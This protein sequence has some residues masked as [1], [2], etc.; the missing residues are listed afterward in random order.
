MPRKNETEQRIIESAAL[1]FTGRGYSDAVFTE[2]VQ[3]ARANPAMINYYFR[4]KE[5]LYRR[6]LSYSLARAAS[7][8]PI[9][10]VQDKTPQQRLKT[11]ISAQLHRTFSQGKAGYFHGMLASEFA[12]PTSVAD[13]WLFDVEKR[14]KDVLES[15][16]GDLLDGRGS[17]SR[18]HSL[19]ILVRSLVSFMLFNRRARKNFIRQDGYSPK[20]IKSLADRFTRYA[21]ACIR[22]KDDE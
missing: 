2:I 9:S 4:N 11:F 18:I 17:P 14:E 12:N 13:D 22:M 19:V 21:L 1:V 5:T 6:A 10:I 8:Y 16:I 15:I 3:K 7:R 20:A